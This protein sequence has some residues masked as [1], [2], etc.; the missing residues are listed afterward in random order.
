MF[1]HHYYPYRGASAP[2]TNVGGGVVD[3]E[4]SNTVTT[5]NLATNQGPHYGFNIRF[6]PTP[7][8]I[9]SVRVRLK[10]PGNSEMNTPYSS[11]YDHMMRINVYEINQLEDYQGFSGYPVDWNTASQADQRPVASSKWYAGDSALG[12]TTGTGTD[13]YFEFSGWTPQADTEYMFAMQ[14]DGMVYNLTGLAVFGYNLGRNNGPDTST[15]PAQVGWYNSGGL[16]ASNGAL[17]NTSL[18]LGDDYA[19]IGATVY[20]ASG[21]GSYGS[22]FEPASSAT[23]TELIKV[24]D[25]GGTFS[26]SAYSIGGSGSDFYNR[27]GFLVDLSSYPNISSITGF[28]LP[29]RKYSFSNPSLDFRMQGSF[30]AV[31]GDGSTETS[32]LSATMASEGLTLFSADELTTTS[33]DYWFSVPEVAID[34]SWTKLFVGIQKEYVVTEIGNST[35]RSFSSVIGASQVQVEFFNVGFVDSTVDP[36]RGDEGATSG[37]L[38][39]AADQPLS[40]YGTLIPA[41]EDPIT[42]IDSGS[43]AVVTI[44]NLLST[45]ETNALKIDVSQLEPEPG[46]GRPVREVYIE[47]IKAITSGVDVDIL[48]DATSPQHC[49]SL[50]GNSGIDWD[51]RAIGPLTNNAGAGKTGNILFST[52]GATAGSS[53]SVTLAMRKKY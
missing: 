16:I 37:D 15:Y 32:A 5:T 53:Y 7:S 44:S 27:L 10:R 43:L 19:D 1:G 23:G 38:F 42:S 2:Q 28:T 52:N 20:S 36:I 24:D 21:S 41:T 18:F 25:A 11:Y 33:T 35:D 47:R 51:F 14:H 50:S 6:G 46:T 39:P 9:T 4:R 45:D 13:F 31:V 3:Q 8:E 26:A 17:S 34:P 49:L 29:L 22:A 30:R 48:W 40:I 12:A